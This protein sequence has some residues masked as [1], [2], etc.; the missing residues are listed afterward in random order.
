MLDKKIKTLIQI[1]KGFKNY[2]IKTDNI[3]KLS[4]ERMKHCNSCNHKSNK[5]CLVPNTHPCCG[6][7]GCSLKLKTRSEE[8]SC[9]INKW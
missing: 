3:E 8:A 9:P 5:Q 7:C 2:F 6:L 1:L 4:K